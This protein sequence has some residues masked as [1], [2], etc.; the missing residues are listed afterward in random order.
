[1]S[2]REQEQGQE[3][4]Q[5]EEEEQGQG[6]GLR[7]RRGIRIVMDGP[8]T[9]VDVAA[10][11]QAAPLR[12]ADSV[13]QLRAES[14]AAMTAPGGWDVE[15]SEDMRARFEQWR[16]RRLGHDDMEREDDDEEEQDDDDLP[17]LLDYEEA[18]AQAERDRRAEGTDERLRRIAVE[19]LSEVVAVV[20]VVVLTLRGV[21][22]F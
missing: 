3:R 1:M 2:E 5:E 13:R 11:I 9:E 4:G 6:Q 20:V 18:A 16:A 8:T 15:I 22:L 10:M 19:D 14:I 12:S 21:V 7:G 17:D